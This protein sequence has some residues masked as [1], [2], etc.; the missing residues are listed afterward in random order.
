MTLEESRRAVEVCRA[1][2]NQ[3]ITDREADAKALLWAINYKDVDVGIFE[4]A[5]FNIMR[6]RKYFPELV[7][8]EEAISREKLLSWN[9]KKRPLLI[10]GSKNE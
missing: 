4:A 6:T 8:L 9:K 1:N 5:I 2:Y 10:G 7:D 3:R